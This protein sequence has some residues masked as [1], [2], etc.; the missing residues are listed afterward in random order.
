LLQFNK[1]DAP[2]SEL[3]FGNKRVSFPKSSR[4]LY[5]GETSV[6]ASLNEPPKKLPISPLIRLVLCVHV[7]GYSEYLT[8]SPKW[9]IVFSPVC[10][11]FSNV[12]SFP[13]RRTIMDQAATA[14]LRL[15]GFSAGLRDRADSAPRTHR[16]ESDEAL[17]EQ[18]GQGCNEALT[19]LFRRHGRMI[20]TISKRILRDPAE[21]EDLVQEVFLY[22]YRKAAAY[23]SAKGTGRSWL[24]QVTYT[25]A[26]LRRREMKAHGLYASGIPDSRPVRSTEHRCVAEYDL[27]VEGLFGRARWKKI[28]EELT[29]DQRETLRLHFFEGLTFAEIA[30]KL[31][32][33]HCNIRN[34]H[35]RG[36]EKL[37][38][39]LANSEL[40]DHSLV[41][42]E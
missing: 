9:G 8:Y 29:E 21:A 13:D 22:V 4:Y 20:W 7:Y 34:H 16:E 10:T 31:G 28:V 24:V 6:L 40:S 27:T 35:Y 15:P 39:H 2:F 18:A 11:S 3:T 33:T 26:F 23:D 5:L 30:E 17:L 25:Q 14:R 19:V 42:Y 37:R 38:K 41:R 32:Q 1:I 12:L 36:L